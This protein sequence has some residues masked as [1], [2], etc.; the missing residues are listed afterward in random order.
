MG[1][2]ELIEI[3]GDDPDI[4]VIGGGG[5]GAARLDDL[6][7]V[8]GADAAPSGKF[9]GKDVDGQ[10]KP[11]DSG[12]GGGGG[13]SDGPFSYL[14]TQDSPA[15]VWVVNHGLPFIPSGIEVYDNVGTK[16]YPTVTWPTGTSVRLDFNFDVRGTARLS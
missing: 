2:V 16:H 11:M 8:S 5:F 13:G 4:V 9:L 1:D 6:T 3:R 12:G 15:T 14:H 10:W 7:D